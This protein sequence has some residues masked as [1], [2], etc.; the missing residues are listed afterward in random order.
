MT[1]FMKISPKGTKFF[2][3]E[4]RSARKGEHGQWVIT[5]LLDEYQFESTQYHYYTKNEA[6]YNAEI[7]Y[8]LRK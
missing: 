4:F 3:A 6:I 5:M 1:Q 8:G 7:A 2:E